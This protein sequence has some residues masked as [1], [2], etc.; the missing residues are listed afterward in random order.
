MN[1]LHGEWWCWTRG[2]SGRAALLSG[3]T[4]RILWSV[5]SWRASTNRP[6]NGSRERRKKRNKFVIKSLIMICVLSKM[7]RNAY[8]AILCTIWGRT[9]SCP[10]DRNDTEEGRPGRPP[11]PTAPR[12][13]WSAALTNLF[14]TSGHHK[15]PASIQRIIHPSIRRK[16]VNVLIT[17][18]FRYYYYLGV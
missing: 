14:I 7:G 3:W 16:K 2:K 18:S 12:R 8:R 10:P 15:N 13:Q 5:G 17:I 9:M 4:D 11:P 6:Q 1:N